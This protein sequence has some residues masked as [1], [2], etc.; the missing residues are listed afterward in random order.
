MKNTINRR[1]FLRGSAVAGAA[2]LAT[3]ALADGHGTTLKMQAA[4]GGGIFLENAQPFAARSCALARPMPVPPPVTRACFPL[5]VMVVLSETDASLR[6]H[7]CGAT[8][9][10]AKAQE[11]QTTRC[12]ARGQTVS[13]GHEIY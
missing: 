12:R 5:S 3:P 10:R 7:W 9:R 6:P 13:V 2:A 4:W 11:T 8:R 1:K